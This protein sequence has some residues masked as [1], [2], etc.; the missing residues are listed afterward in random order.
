MALHGVQIVETCLRAIKKTWLRISEL[1]ASISNILCE[2]SYSIDFY[3]A[4]LEP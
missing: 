4:P 1:R 2:Y 3:P